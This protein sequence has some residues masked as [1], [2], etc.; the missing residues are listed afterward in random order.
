M[1]SRED[2]WIR[3]ARRDLEQARTSSSA[4]YYEWACF[5][6]QQ[7]A[8][9][10]VK[11]VFQEHHLEAWGHVVHQLLDKWPAEETPS[12]E[13]IDAARRLDRHYIPTRYPTAS[14]PER[15][16][17]SIPKRM[18][19]RPSSMRRPSLPSVRVLSPDWRKV[20]RAVEDWATALAG[21]DPNVLGVLLY[22]SLARGDSRPVPT[23][24]LSWSLQTPPTGLSSGPTIYRLS[25][26]RS[27]TRSWSTPKANCLA[28]NRKTGPSFA[29]PWRRAGGWPGAVRWKRRRSPVRSIRL[30]RSCQRRRDLDPALIGMCLFSLL[31]LHRLAFGPAFS[32][33]SF[34]SRPPFVPK[35]CS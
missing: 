26:C 24:T 20:F 14:S 17:I 2:D 1:L 29:V 9:K 4:G 18:R 12:A 22:G 23:Q 27:A 6:A 31:T 21:A 25:G 35:C 15:P 28:S 30:G 33:P 34:A 16:E 32:S 10:A 19:S 5:A 7:A 3:Q 13:L 8:E 11:A